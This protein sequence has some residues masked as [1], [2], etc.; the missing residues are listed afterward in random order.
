MNEYTLSEIAVGM[1]ASFERTITREMEEMFRKISGD[2]NPLHWDDEY[3]GQAGGGRFNGHVC[4]GML[5]ASLYSA[6]AGMYLPGK[7]SLIHSLEEVCFMNPVFVGDTLQVT[8]EVTD[9]DEALG[10]IRLKVEI[11]NGQGKKVSR[12]KMKVLVLKR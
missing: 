9:K 3:A 8:G 4:Y 7:Y 2:D 6:M 12:A 1:K 10:L 5:T 11:R